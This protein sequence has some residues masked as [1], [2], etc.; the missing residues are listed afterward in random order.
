MW[1]ELLPVI[2][3]VVGVAAGWAVAR[4]EQKADV[5]KN[6]GEPDP[7]HP[8][9]IC[10]I[11]EDVHG[12]LLQCCQCG[13]YVC[14][15][16][17]SVLRDMGSKCPLCRHE[18]WGDDS[19]Q[20]L[21]GLMLRRHLDPRVIYGAAYA[22]AIHMRL[23]GDRERERGFLRL[24]ALQGNPRAAEQLGEMILTGVG[25]PKDKHEGQRWLHRANTPRS[26]ELLCANARDGSYREI[27]TLLSL[28]THPDVP[29]VTMAA[30]YFRLAELISVVEP[31]KSL[32]YFVFAATLGDADAMAKVG[33]AM[34]TG[35]GIRRNLAIGSLWYRQAAKL[36]NVEARCMVGLMDFYQTPINSLS[37]VD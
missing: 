10:K 14:G 4:I 27:I 1:W 6:G 19:L 13:G 21:I 18:E 9:P 36:G 35:T 24:S 12:E 37:D 23:D 2:A 15:G 33:Q 22:A 26:L 11:V 17:A 29:Q 16:C 8:C 20:D 7:E 28:T 25:G 30:T 32:K 3:W 5:T 31:A 34:C